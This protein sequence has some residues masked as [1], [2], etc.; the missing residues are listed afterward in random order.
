MAEDGAGKRSKSGAPPIPRPA[1]PELR[2]RP[3]AKS[4]PSKR[5]PDDRPS[6]RAPNNRGSAEDSSSEVSIEQ[7]HTGGRTAHPRR[8]CIPERPPSVTGLRVGGL[9][10]RARLRGRSERRRCTPERRRAAAPAEARSC[11]PVGG[12]AAPA[13]QGRI[14]RA[15]ATPV[16]VANIGAAAP[17]GVSVNGAPRTPTAPGAATRSINLATP[18]ARADVCQARSPIAAS[19]IIACAFAASATGNARTRP[20]ALERTHGLDRGRRQPCRARACSVRA[21]GAPRPERGRRPRHSVCAGRAREGPQ[22]H[23]DARSVAPEAAC[24]GCRRHAPDAR[25]RGRSPTHRPV[26]CA[27]R[28]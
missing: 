3:V 17:K 12:S 9:G 8:G 2:T 22:P 1:P 7:P 24:S 13:A 18:G 5:E 6:P 4:T 16:E 10:E 20:R 14:R 15:A 25:R 27:R 11:S 19:A 23:G 21:R 26:R 28:C